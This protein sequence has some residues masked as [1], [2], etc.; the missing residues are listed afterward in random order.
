LR[1]VLERVK[2]QTVYL[3]GVDPGYGSPSAFLGRLAG[4]VKHAL[5]TRDGGAR[6]SELAAATAAREA[7]VRAGLTW[8]AA[9]GSIGLTFGD[10]DAVSVSPG[11]GVARPDLAQV[12]RR[13]EALLAET[14]AYRAYFASA[15]KERLVS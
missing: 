7:T 14:A 8:L 4:L 13:L 15:D 3:F 1:A 6:I 9:R 10:G 5:S 2:P 12:T 11:D